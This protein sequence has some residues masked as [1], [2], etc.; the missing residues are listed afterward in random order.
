MHLQKEVHY[1]PPREVTHIRPSCKSED[2]PDRWHVEDPIV[3]WTS[4]VTFEVQSL[5]APPTGYSL[6]HYNM[7]IRGV[8]F[9]NT[10]RKE[11]MPICYT[12][13]VAGRQVL[14]IARRLHFSKRSRTSRKREW[15][16]QPGL[17]GHR[18]RR[19]RSTLKIRRPRP[20]AAK[21]ANREAPPSRRWRFVRFAES[22]SSSQ[23]RLGCQ[24]GGKPI[25]F[26][27][28]YPF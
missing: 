4:K 3:S 11:E 22:R 26:Y 2:T 5:L 12:V 24:K 16:M 10:E 21:W 7:Q 17:A 28:H 14:T 25:P 1:P 27:P 23:G 15:T 18:A 19:N 9:K 8:A 20:R 6:R 13:G